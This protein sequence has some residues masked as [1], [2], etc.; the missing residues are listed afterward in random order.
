MT[1]L[2]EPKKP[3]ASS[4]EAEGRGGRIVT[5][6]SL[7]DNRLRLCRTGME[8]DQVDDGA[9]SND[10]SKASDCQRGQALETKTLRLVLSPERSSTATGCGDRQHEVAEWSDPWQVWGFRVRSYIEHFD[11]ITFLTVVVQHTRE[12]SPAEVSRPFFLRE[13]KL[14]CATREIPGFFL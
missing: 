12:E 3:S 6:V 8:C 4:V 7:P 2:M 13:G 1:S 10:E 9:E 5:S 14:R 11:S